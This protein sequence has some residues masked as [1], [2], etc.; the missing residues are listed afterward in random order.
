[1]PFKYRGR[2][3]RTP[4][5]S[6]G[7]G[8]RQSIK[9][10]WKAKQRKKQGLNTRT[11]LANRRAI[12]KIVKSRE[13]KYIQNVQGTSL[14]G[15]A[16]QWISASQ[17]DSFGMD[18]SAPA[19]PLSLRVLRGLGRGND[20]NQRIGDWIQIKSVT[21]HCKFTPPG[22]ALT[23]EAFNKLRIYCVLDTEPLAK[24]ATVAGLDDIPRM[25]Y[26]RDTS[27]TSDMFMNYYNPEM[28]GKEARFKVLA[29]KT[30]SV[31]YVS[32]TT[33]GTSTS[34]P[35]EQS[36]TFNFGKGYKIQYLKDDPTVPCNQELV[37]MAHSDSRLNPHPYVEL[38]CK[39]RYYDA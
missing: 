24:S 15:Y 34:Y 2:K 14:N 16:G 18:T 23:T 10:A 33:A 28:T 9:N 32:P 5:F 22:A 31:G 37:I 39:V 29:V 20:P 1:M 12:K 35:P 27:V 17:V 19:Q 36:F 38:K 13:T 6:K 30:A 11:T 26:L 3:V 21:V 25:T 8:K 7:R 4:A